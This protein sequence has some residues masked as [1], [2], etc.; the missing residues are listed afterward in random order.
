MMMTTTTSLKNLGPQTR[1]GW[2][3]TVNQLGQ[4]KTS[5]RCGVDVVVVGDAF[6]Y[7]ISDDGES[8]AV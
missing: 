1:E 5:K 8:L 4:N 6:L 2:G 7:A 3:H